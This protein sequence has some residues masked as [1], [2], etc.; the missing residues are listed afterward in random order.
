MTDDNGEAVKVLF[1]GLCMYW[2]IPYLKDGHLGEGAADFFLPAVGRYALIVPETYARQV[3]IG[4]LHAH[5]QDP[6]MLNRED[7]LY[8]LQTGDER[9]FA[10]KLRDMARGGTRARD[11][12]LNAGLTG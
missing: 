3:E 11:A 12:R 8:L 2:D 4:A 9:T 5:G 6:I 1:E 7:L 10:A